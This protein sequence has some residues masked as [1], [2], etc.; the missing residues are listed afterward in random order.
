V[1]L[2]GE[3]NVT[4]NAAIEKEQFANSVSFG[5]PL[6]SGP[7][8]HYI[9]VGEGEGEAKEA[10]AITAG[11][12]KGTV[13][14]PQAAPGNLCVF[15][16]TEE[17]SVKEEGGFKIPLICSWEGGEAGCLI[18]I[19][20]TEGSRFGFGIQAEA[21]AAGILRDTGTWVVTAK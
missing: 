9:Y 2:I 18:T 20:E 21:A 1:E 6:V 4:G 14:E 8:V 10:A 19:L 16:A 12:C 15:G 5:L 3:W 17:N 7:L 11:K 13:T